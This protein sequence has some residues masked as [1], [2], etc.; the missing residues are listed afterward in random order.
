MEMMSKEFL[1]IIA[2]TAIVVGGTVFKG[3]EYINSQHISVLKEQIELQ[4]TISNAGPI[5]ID[6]PLDVKKD[7]SQDSN[8]QKLLERVELLEGERA[9]LLKQLSNNA[10]D[11][12]DP[13]SEVGTLLKKVSSDIDIEEAVATLFEIKSPISFEPLADYYMKNHDEYGYL[14]GKSS[15]KWFEF[16]A[17]IDLDSGLKFAV[18]MLDKS[19]FPISDAYIFLKRSVSSKERCELVVQDLQ[20]IALTS[21]IPTARGNAKLLLA[22]EDTAKTSHSES[23][24][25]YV[26]V[27]AEIRVYHLIYNLFNKHEIEKDF[28]LMVMHSSD[29]DY[30]STGSFL[31]NKAMFDMGGD[32]YISALESLSKLEMR[33]SSQGFILLLLSKVY[34]QNKRMDDAK[35]ALDSCYAVAPRVC[36]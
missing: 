2:A 1:G 13:T 22:C 26:D 27:Y 25:D 36:G 11:S 16:F 5:G 9:E 19:N 12:L 28:H 35:D 31:Y 7:A 34:E 3:M 15:R 23:P 32:R 14:A 21:A 20:K 18:S 6:F 10:V 24:W 33:K 4:E 30:W 29:I 8:S 17:S